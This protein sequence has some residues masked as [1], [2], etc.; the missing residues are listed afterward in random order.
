MRPEYTPELKSSI[1]IVDTP[2]YLDNDS[3][4]CTGQVDKSYYKPIEMQINL[5][6]KPC[7]CALCRHNYQRIGIK[8]SIKWH[9]AQASYY[10]KKV[11]RLIDRGIKYAILSEED[12]LENQLFLASEY[13]IFHKDYCYY[14]RQIRKG[15]KECM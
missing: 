3:S 7:Y 14:L 1:S 6:L 9:S 2:V 4:K 10:K 12:T 13:Y 15:L 11:K 8:K 5:K